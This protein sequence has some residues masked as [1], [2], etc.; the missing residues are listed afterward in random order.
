MDIRWLRSGRVL[1]RLRELRD[2][3]V[4][5]PRGK[6]ARGGR[7]RGGDARGGHARRQVYHRLELHQDISHMG[8]SPRKRL[9]HWFFMELHHIHSK[10]CHTHSG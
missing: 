2:R 4:D 1:Y 3:L 6:E 7:T 10:S 8:P 5:A 9:L